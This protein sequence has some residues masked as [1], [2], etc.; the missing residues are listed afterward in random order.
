MP[1]ENRVIKKPIQN[2]ENH[3]DF[4]TPHERPSQLGMKMK[5]VRGGAES[6]TLSAAGEVRLHRGGSY[7]PFVQRGRIAQENSSM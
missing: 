5:L 1:Q 2:M 7:T 6:A 4:S 3:I